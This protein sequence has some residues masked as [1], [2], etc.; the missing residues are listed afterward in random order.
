MTVFTTKD[1]VYGSTI[2]VESQELV[3]YDINSSAASQIIVEMFNQ[4]YQPLNQLDPA[5]TIQL[6]I[7]EKPASDL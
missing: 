2:T 7:R 3:W 1:T 5:T 4:D 6:L